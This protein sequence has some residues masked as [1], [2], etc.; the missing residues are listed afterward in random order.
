MKMER[1]YQLYLHYAGGGPVLLL[2]LLIRHGCGLVQPFIFGAL[3]ALLTSGLATWE[4]MLFSAGAMVLLEGLSILAEYLFNCR[5]ARETAKMAAQLKV[6]V[7]E[8]FHALDYETREGTS[9]GEWEQRIGGD[10][11][12]V[13]GCSCPVFSD[14]HG[15]AVVFVLST[16]IILWGQP[17]FF[18]PI[19]I[20][21]LL[22]WWVYRANKEML[23]KSNKEM[24]KCGYQEWGALLDTLSLMP[25][26]RLFRV[27]SFQSKRYIMFAVGSRDAEIASA[28]ISSGYT[29]QIRGLMWFSGSAVLVLSL[30]LYAHGI[31]GIAEVVAYDM[32]VGQISGQLGQLIFCIPMLTRGAES[33]AALESAFGNLTTACENGADEKP[34][35]EQSEHLL[36]L[37]G[38]RFRYRNGSR[39][40]LSGL[41]W[42]VEQ[43]QYISI[44]G[45]NGE[46]KS[47]LIK[48]LLGE[49]TPTAGLVS[50]SVKR[51]GY[52][53]QASAVFRGSLGDNLTLCNRAISQQ[54]VEE[55]VKQTRLHQLAERVGGLSGE[56]SREQISG[57]ELQRI[58]IA[59][60]LLIEP[61]LL[62]V[63]EITNNLDMANKA[64]IFRI[65]QE[66]KH[67]CAIVSISHDIESLTDSDECLLLAEGRLHVI[68]G[69][70]PER[71][72]EYAYNMIA[73]G[74]DH[75]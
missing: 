59:R 63:D 56:I 28:R 54:K 19:V 21:S 4:S 13:A 8:R 3:V 47:T 70:T 65:L 17:F 62:V 60:A 20:I 49:L 71:K 55:V 7:L 45:K 29:G 40:I 14:L 33:A 61:D 23:V 58:G 74:Y 53:P 44:L 5:V 25:I 34:V 68:E 24:R 11:Q 72:R 27:E 26:M 1:L 10:P 46:G 66:M 67:R 2:L 9:I 48:L 42:G 18:I 32:L 69:D 50:G 36:R 22:L 38:V 6:T 57:G 30:V 31:I 52:V 15:A 16:G 41:D 73:G 75:E 35:I 12:T 51:P 64:L 37:E 39:D 43:G